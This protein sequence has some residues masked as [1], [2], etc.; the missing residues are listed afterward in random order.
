MVS[1]Q[2]VPKRGSVGSAA[3]QGRLSV[4]A[5]PTL[6][7]FGT[8]C[9]ATLI[10]SVLLKAH[11]TETPRT[12]RLHEKNRRTQLRPWGGTDCVDTTLSVYNATRS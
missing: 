3:P 1:Q 7:R 10:R 12:Q 11:T 2:S 9:S 8:D 5:D 6:P 4:E